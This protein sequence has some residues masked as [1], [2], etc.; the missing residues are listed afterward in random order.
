MLRKKR[1]EREKTN[2]VRKT[3]MEKRRNKL[4]QT[5]SLPFY[6]VYGE[7]AELNQFVI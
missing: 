1:E 2:E 5:M 3:I 7:V 6:L 4:G